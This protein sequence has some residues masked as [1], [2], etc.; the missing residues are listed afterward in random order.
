[1]SAFLE[2]LIREEVEEQSKAI[3]EGMARGL[4]VDAMAGHLGITQEGF[5]KLVRE[6]EEIREA[7]KVGEAKGVLYIERLAISMA[8]ENGPVLQT[9]LRNRLGW[10]AKDAANSGNLTVE[11]KK[12]VYAEAGEKD[13]DPK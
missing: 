7:L 10:D 4:S 13:S 2:K 3:V 11:V 12:F 9:L 5:D 1:M 6:E 8:S